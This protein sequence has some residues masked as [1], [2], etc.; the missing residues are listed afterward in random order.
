MSHSRSFH[1]IIAASKPAFE[2]MCGATPIPLFRFARQSFPTDRVADVAAATRAALAAPGC[3]DRV[4]PGMRIAVCVGSRGI[5][6][7]PLLAR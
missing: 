7:L 3:L 4:K 2:K 5:A 1:E 6:N